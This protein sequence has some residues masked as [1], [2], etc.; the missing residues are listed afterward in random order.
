M[1]SPR[2]SLCSHILKEVIPALV[3][4]VRPVF[5]GVFASRDLFAL[6]SC[7]PMACIKWRSSLWAQEAGPLLAPPRAAS[8]LQ[9]RGL[10]APGLRFPLLNGLISVPPFGRLQ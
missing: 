8:V 10:P 6:S 9:A 7:L 5:T 3:Q 2:R 1:W 4:F